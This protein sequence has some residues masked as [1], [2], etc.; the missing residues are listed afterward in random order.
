MIQH[1]FARPRWRAIFVGASACAALPL[2]AQLRGSW[3]ANAALAQFDAPK[4]ATATPTNGPTDPKW[5]GQRAM[6]GSLRFSNPFAQLSADGVLRDGDVATHA[7]GGVSAL[8][9]T[10]AWK[11][12]RFSVSFDGRHVPNDG[13]KYDSTSLILRATSDKNSRWQSL[14]SANISY[15]KNAT[16]WWLRATNSQGVVLS[17]SVSRWS[18][19]SGLTHQF[20]NVSMGISFGGNKARVFQK[21]SRPRIKIDS[22]PITEPGR[23]FPGKSDTTG[24]TVTSKSVPDTGSSAS[25]RRW[26]EAGASIGWARGRFALDATLSA[27]PKLGSY[28]AAVWG[29]VS[30][31]AGVTSHVAVVAATHSIPDSPGIVF[32]AQRSASIGLRIA[33]PAMFR[34]PPPT[35]IRSASTG[36]RVQANGSGNY[37]I[38]MTVPNARSVELAGDFTA[39]EAIKLRQLDATHWEIA[40]SVASG[41]HRC[42]VRIDGADWVPPPGLPSIKDEFNGR[43]GLF[44]AE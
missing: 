12:L 19:L 2:H 1:I 21:Y 43:V 20:G 3:D 40:L 11:H 15:A 14:A 10:P 6:G 28:T 35:P 5:L 8:F 24:Y 18:I 37:T 31:V 30:A 4:V 41:S 44:V 38:T 22:V 7:T 29:D 9:A 33:P 32:S 27:R 13:A 26:S 36:F 34:P 39:W 16:G 17:D 23:A 25:W 42:N